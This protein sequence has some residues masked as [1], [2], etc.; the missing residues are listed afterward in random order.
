MNALLQSAIAFWM[1]DAPEAR[2][3]CAALEGKCVVVELSDLGV[4]FTLRPG[5]DGI[6]VQ[7][8][9]DPD[10]HA[11]IRAPSLDLLRLSRGVGSGDAI[12]RVHVEGDAELAQAMRDLLRDVPFDAEERLARIIGDVPAH[13]LGRVARGMDALARDAL[14]R[15]EQ[16]LGE[17]LKHESRDLPRPDEVS[18]FVA[19]VDA[20]RDDVARAEARL[21]RIQVAG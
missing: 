12:G 16:M 17:F 14:R 9:D 19:A 21:Q 8:R 5:E 3:R 18:R 20:L 7:L 11:R 4:V 2:R 10:A 15:M 1:A 6:E 13:E